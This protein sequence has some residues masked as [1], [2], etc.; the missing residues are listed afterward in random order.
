M[1]NRAPKLIG[2]VLVPCPRGAVWVVGSDPSFN[3]GRVGACARAGPSLMPLTARHAEARGLQFSILRAVAGVRSNLCQYADISDNQNL[4][5]YRF[6]ESARINKKRP[7]N[8]SA[9]TA[10]CAGDVGARQ[11]TAGRPRRPHPSRA[12]W[13][14]GGGS[15]SNRGNGPW[16]PRCTR[17]PNLAAADEL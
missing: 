7:I 6:R 12:D 9:L 13:A 8:T 10:A 5:L 2:I 14:K 4:N 11:A 1:L 16:T 3:S 15:L 17:R